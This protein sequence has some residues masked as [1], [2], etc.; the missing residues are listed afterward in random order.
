MNKIICDESQLH[1]FYD[2]I[3]CRF[4]PTEGYF[5]TLSA[6]NKYLTE[7]EQNEYHLG[8]SEMMSP[9]LLTHDDFSVLLSRL[10]RYEC[11]SEGFTTK[12]GKPI[13]QKALAIY[14]NINPSSIVKGINKFKKDTDDILDDALY[15]VIKGSKPNF[16]KLS[17]VHSMFLTSFQNIYSR[18]LWL[19]I[20]MDVSKD[21]KFWESPDWK[22]ICDFYNLGIKDYYILDTHSGFHLLI[23]T[24]KI[25]FDPN[26][27]IR[28]LTNIYEIKKLQKKEIIINKNS[29]IPCPGTYAGEYP[30]KFIK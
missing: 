15:S 30:I 7:E 18:K 22:L 13:P 14:A 11:N 6:R 20:D 1:Y 2:S 17:S 12:N 28:A 5:F 24:S 3:M 8:R 9:I 26:N 29:M 21:F 19:D 16:D 25:K 27:I 10:K 4:N 23:S